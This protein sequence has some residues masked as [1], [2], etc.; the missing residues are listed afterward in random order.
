MRTNAIHIFTADDDED[1]DVGLDIII[2][3]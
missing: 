1:E 3:L 2:W